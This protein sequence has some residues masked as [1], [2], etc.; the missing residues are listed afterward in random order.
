MV[1]PENK[2]DNDVT[3]PINLTRFISTWH[4]LS[5]SEIDSLGYDEAKCNHL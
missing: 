1:V 5:G 3:E 4:D 2:N